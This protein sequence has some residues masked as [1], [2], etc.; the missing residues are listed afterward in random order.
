VPQNLYTLGIGYTLSIKANSKVADQAAK[1][2]DW[3]YSTPQRAL[4][5]TTDI[6]NPPPPIPLKTSDFPAKMDPRVKRH[7]QELYQATSSGKFG[8]TT[9]TFWPA[10]SDVIAYQSLDKV[11]AGD[12][13][14]AQFCAQMADTFKQERA[15]GVVPPIPKGQN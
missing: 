6:N 5:E 11:L 15:Q 4:Q 7:Y 1:Y 2:L 3:L 10:K 13:T 9:W 12:L 14:P 8:Y